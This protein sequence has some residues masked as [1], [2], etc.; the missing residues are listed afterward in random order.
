M[1]KERKSLSK[2]DECSSFVNDRKTI[3][4]EDKR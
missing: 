2:E 1:E 4:I 3:Y